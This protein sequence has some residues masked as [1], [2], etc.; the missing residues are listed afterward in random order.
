LNAWLST[1]VPKELDNARARYIDWARLRVAERAALAPEADRYV[2][3]L[4]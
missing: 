4:H 2:Q 3:Q 1:R